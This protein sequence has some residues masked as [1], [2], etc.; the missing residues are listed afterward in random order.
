MKSHTRQDDSQN[1]SDQYLNRVILLRWLNIFVAAVV[2]FF[3]VQLVFEVYGDKVFG[4][5]LVENM[6]S[7]PRLLPQVL[8]VLIAMF[9]T[10]GLFRLGMLGTEMQVG[11]RIFWRYPPMIIAVAPSCFLIFWY[12]VHLISGSGLFRSSSIFAWIVVLN[13]VASGGALA[14]VREMLNDQHQKDNP[15]PG[16]PTNI[17]IRAEPLES[18][19]DDELIAWIM[20]EN[21]VEYPNDDLFNHAPIARR[22]AK[23]LLAMRPMT[24]AVTGPFGC[25]KSTV[26]NFVKYY[27]DHPE[28][29][30]SPAIPNEGIINRKVITCTVDGWGREGDSLAGQTL[31]LAIKEVQKYVD[32]STVISLPATYRAALQSKGLAIGTIISAVFGKSSTPAAQLRRFDD[33]LIAADI[34]LVLMFEDLDRNMDEKVLGVE[35]P[36]LLDRI[37][38]LQNISYVLAVGTER[39]ARDMLDRLCDRVEDVA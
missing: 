9:V 3:V 26:L 19:S 12:L 30:Y 14:V 5:N 22:I 1:V 11:L 10:T 32:T 8:L 38:R 31:A 2:Q 21:P 34:R 17:E 6:A 20:S 36:G 29:L 15:R 18:N 13:S 37:R 24:I 35:L 28:T 16:L 23:N 39:F 27:M 7:W 33:I 25:G 4:K